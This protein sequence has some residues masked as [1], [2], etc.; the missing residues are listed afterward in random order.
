ML[1]IEHTVKIIKVFTLLILKTKPETL[2]P[3]A[4][5]RDN[6]KQASLK[7]NHRLRVSIILALV[8]MGEEG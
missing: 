7:I 4:Y 6:L 1:Y 8:I 3:L 5:L 2:A